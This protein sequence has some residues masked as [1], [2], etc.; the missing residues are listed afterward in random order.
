[1]EAVEIPR[2]D[3]L[4]DWYGPIVATVNSRTAPGTRYTVRCKNNVLSCTCQS[5]MESR[6]IPQRCG[7][8]NVVARNLE[9]ESRS[10]DRA[11]LICEELLDVIGHSVPPGTLQR[12]AGCLR[13]YLAIEVRRTGPNPTKRSNKLLATGARLITLDD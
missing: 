9:A 5:Y 12:M 8:T 3:Q 1:M 2:A 11:T 13:P 7:H 4:E 6:S 10:K